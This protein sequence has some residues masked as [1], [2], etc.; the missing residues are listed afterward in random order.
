MAGT[1]NYD[2]PFNVGKQY[3]QGV[4][5]GKQVS[6]WSTPS[7]DPNGNMAYGTWFQPEYGQVLDKNAMAGQVA[8]NYGRKADA[9]IAAM[10]GAAQNGINTLNSQAGSVYPYIQ[11]AEQAY[12]AMGQGIQGSY[13]AANDVRG[14]GTQ[15]A[16]FMQTFRGYGDTL[17]NQGNA[18]L[19]TGNQIIGQGQG[20]LNMNSDMGGLGGEYVKWLQGINPDSF[21]SM[22]AVDTQRAG[23]NALGQMERG[24]SRSG[25]DVGGARSAALRQQYAQSLASALAGAK[26]RAR[27]QGRQ[28][29][30]QALQGAFQTAG[31]LVSQGTQVTGQGLQAQGMAGQMQQSAVQAGQTAGQLYGAAGNL[32]A[33]GAQL[34]GQQAAGYGN[35]AQTKNQT[36]GLTLQAQ[37][38]LTAAQQAAA[39]YYA[40][41]GQGFGQVAGSGGIMSALFGS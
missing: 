37:N 24:L 39:Q 10:I 38:N 31:G 20:I 14:I 1:I 26:T 6:A 13:Q 36:L 23:Q 15:I 8:V 7:L 11:Q 27:I 16:P 25:V 5:G 22:A 2:D 12:G 4:V 9:S 33:Q 35:L 18:L 17:W 30:G 21:V 19:G 32:Q 41:T 34:Q 28:A 29:Q 40:Q 3:K